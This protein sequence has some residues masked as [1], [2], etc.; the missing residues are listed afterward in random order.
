MQTHH[1]LLHI[2]KPAISPLQ[3]NKKE[4][5]NISILTE[6]KRSNTTC[7]QIVPIVISNSTNKIELQTNAILDTGSGKTLLR[8]DAA[9]K[10]NL[11]LIDITLNNTNVVAT[12]K[13]ISSRWSI[14]K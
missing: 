2:L 5:V 9:D 12:N 4:E 11:Q 7:F 3:H 14:F 8:Q 13:K 6:R 10:L 1:T